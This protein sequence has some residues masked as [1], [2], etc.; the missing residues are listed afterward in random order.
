M[1]WQIFL[2]DYFPIFVTVTSTTTFKKQK[3]S[4]TYTIEAGDP[5]RLR[6]YFITIPDSTALQT[7]NRRENSLIKSGDL[8][9]IDNLNEERERVSRMLRNRGYFNFR[10]ELLFFYV[11]SAL[12]SNEIDAELSIQPQYL[13]ND[14]ALQIIFAQKKIDTITIIALK[15]NKNII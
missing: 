12:N 4:V 8:F 5:Y 13:E 9:D 2:L 6:H 3:A 15:D 7:I 14:S 1:V 10:K 11:D